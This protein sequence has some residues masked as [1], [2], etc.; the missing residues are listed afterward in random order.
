MMIY[1]FFIGFSSRYGYINFGIFKIISPPLTHVNSSRTADP[2]TTAT[3]LGSPM[4]ILD[5]S[6]VQLTPRRAAA[7]KALAAT[8]RANNSPSASTLPLSSSSTS[9]TTPHFII[10]GAGISGL[11]AARQLTYFG[12]KVTILESRVCFSNYFPCCFF[13]KITIFF[14]AISFLLNKHI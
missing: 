4:E 5:K 6:D 13:Y 12:A 8:R 9:L 7:E 3:F 2:A 11:I 1:L 14:N 10:I